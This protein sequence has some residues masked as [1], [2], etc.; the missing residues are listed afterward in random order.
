MTEARVTVARQRYEADNV[1]VLL[2]QSVE[3]NQKRQMSLGGLVILS[4]KL[5][6]P[7]E[8]GSL[9][10]GEQVADVTIALAALLNNSADTPGQTLHIPHGVRKTRLIG[11]WDPAPNLDKVLR[12]EYSFKGVEAVIEVGEQV[13]L[14]LPP[15]T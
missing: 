4:A 13:E 5:G 12:V 2:A 7:D 3:A 8:E 1:A 6:V 15:P 10:T 11:F 9:A 14:T